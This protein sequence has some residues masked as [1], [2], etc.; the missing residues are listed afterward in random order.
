[1]G[2]ESGLNMSGIDLE[3]VPRIH[4]A[5]DLTDPGIAG[6]PE[7]R[8]PGAGAIPWGVLT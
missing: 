8:N 7:N 6:R 1:M 5:S 4:L 2:M 3:S